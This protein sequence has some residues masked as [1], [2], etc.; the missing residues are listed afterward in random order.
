MP[1]K[2]QSHYDPNQ[3]H[4]NFGPGGFSDQYDNERFRSL[5]RDQ[6]PGGVTNVPFED[7]VDLDDMNFNTQKGESFPYENHADRS[8]P[9]RDADLS[10]GEAGTNWNWGLRQSQDLSGRGPKGWKLS[11][12][13]LR[14]RVSEV[15]LHSHDVD[16]SN[17]EVVVEDRVVYLRG[18]IKSKGMRRV[19]EDLVASIPGVEDVFTQLKIEEQDS[20]SYRLS[21]QAYDEA[22]RTDRS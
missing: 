9:D 13:K 12:E 8:E 14:E 18:S 5:D 21:K 7:D 3:V 4:G 20:N 19:A 1:P 11:D 22:R 16:P 17:L 15:L 6:N 10:L 2:K